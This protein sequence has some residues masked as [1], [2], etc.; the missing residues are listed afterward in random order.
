M[1]G[2]R[3]IHFLQ[4]VDFRLPAEFGLGPPVSAAV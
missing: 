2:E 3:E 4:P 1:A